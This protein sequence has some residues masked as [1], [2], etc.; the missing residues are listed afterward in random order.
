MLALSFGET[1][2]VTDNT[3]PEGRSKNRRI[4]ILLRPVPLEMQ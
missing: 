4:E 1:R 3:T 2:P